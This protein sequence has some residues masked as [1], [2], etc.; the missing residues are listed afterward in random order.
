MWLDRI[1]LSPRAQHAW[2][3]ALGLRVDAVQS[4]AAR[5]EM[6]RAVRARAGPELE[7]FCEEA[8]DGGAF[9]V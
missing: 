9:A 7:R 1:Q 4:Q 8:I 2:V 5:L 6:E 3:A